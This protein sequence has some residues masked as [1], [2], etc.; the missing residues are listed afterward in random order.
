M[1]RPKRA[2]NKASTSSQQ[3]QRNNEND[4]ENGG[5]CSTTD[6]TQI[7]NDVQTHLINDIVKM[8]LIA[9]SKKIPI[10]RN[11]INKLILKEYARSF[12][13]IM[14]QV[15]LKLKQVFALDLIEVPS[16]KGSYIIV[17]S[18]KCSEEYCHLTWSDEDNMKHELLALIL[19]MIFMNDNLMYEEDLLKTLEKLDLN[20]HSPSPEF[21]DVGKLLKQEFVR[22]LYLDYNYVKDSDPPQV[23]IRWGERAKLEVSERGILEYVCKVYENI[24]PEEW[25]AQY[26]QI[27][28]NE[29]PTQ[30]SQ[31]Q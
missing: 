15:K 3:S 24:R 14:G 22:Q 9:D 2:V 29:K 12:G 27:L 10:K 30:Q 20:I 31:R 23:E 1:N 13:P 6:A 26:Q 18:I 8:T 25:S 16:K 11:D 17:N 28:R 7:P 4:D 5:N 19:A 21:G